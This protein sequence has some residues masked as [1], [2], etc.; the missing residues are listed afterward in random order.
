MSDPIMASVTALMVSMGM[1]IK[2]TNN[3]SIEKYT[4]RTQPIELH[5][6]NEVARGCV[7]SRIPLYFQLLS[8]KNGTLTTKFEPVRSEYKKDHWSW[9]CNNK[10]ILGIKLTYQA[11]ADYIGIERISYVFIYSNGS[12]QKYSTKINVLK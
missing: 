6:M 8:P 12:A 3:F 11:N 1:P 7:G 2:K 9:K 5:K 10:P 4:V